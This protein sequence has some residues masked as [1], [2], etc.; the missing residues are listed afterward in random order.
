[1]NLLVSRRRALRSA[2]VGVT[3]VAGAAALAA[4]GETQVVT[5][6]VPVEKI[7]V[8]QVEVEK[9]VT[10]TEIK[11][12]PVEKV[13][14]QQ[15]PVE[16][17][18]VQTDTVI[19]E[20]PVQTIVEKVVIQEKIVTVEV[21]KPPERK[22]ATIE[23]HHDHT[24]GT[25]G[26]AM[27]W[28]LDRFA[29]E[30]PHINVKFVPQPAAFTETF[31]IKIVAGTQGEL[32]L[33][34]GWFAWIWIQGGAFT[35][36]NDELAKHDAWDPTGMYAQPDVFTLNLRN[37]RYDGAEPVS[38]PQF[39]VG[40]QG[41]MQNYAYNLTLAEKAG[42]DVPV[43]SDRA[44]TGRWG[45]ETEFREANMKARDPETDTWGGHGNTHWG[46]YVF[47][48]MAFNE[49]PRAMLHWNEDAT[50]FGAFDNGGERGLQA[51]VNMAL[52]DQSL[53]PSEERKTLSGQF[54]DPFS[55]GKILWN[56]MG[57]A[58]GFAIG[59]IQDRFSWTIGANPE[60]L[61]GACPTAF[62]GQP[63]IVTSAATR[64]GTLEETVELA[65]FMGGDEVQTRVAIERGSL[66]I[67]RAAL[68]SPEYKAAPPGANALTAGMANWTDLQ[69]SQ[70]GHPNPLEIWDAPHPVGK[71]FSGELSVGDAIAGL[72]ET[73]D[74]AL[75]RTHESYESLQAFAA[76]LPY[77]NVR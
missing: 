35:Q 77:T 58:V 41:N 61:R 4:C 76:Q 5:K 7:V 20:V 34:S 31:N 37:T 38:G 3:G 49:N 73:K 47:W 60:G 70:M 6:E 45:I 55:A 69:P 19:K 44:G 22:T 33:L 2:V 62:D 39:G 64:N 74:R 9:I 66:P 56:R 63:H 16:R 11:E 18:V 27:K 28:S 68:N 67:T 25:R 24:S 46:A 13:V 65:V 75:A 36:I 42:I 72:V 40:Y 8:E 29:K 26:A 51:G 71:A 23:F 12:V 30:F 32:A 17:V 59:R 54:G 53:F 1:M 15:V 14:I 43:S 48:A 50:H 57:G 10:R 52:E 21:E